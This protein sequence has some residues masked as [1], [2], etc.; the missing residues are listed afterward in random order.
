MAYWPLDVLTNDVNSGMNISPDLGPNGNH[1]SDNFTMTSGDVVAGIR[2]SAVSFDGAA[3]YLSQVYAVGEGRGLPVYDARYYTVSFWVKGIGATQQARAVFAE[4]NNANNNPFFRLTTDWASSGRTNVLAAAIRNDSTP[5][6]NW[7]FGNFTFA[8]QGKTLGTNMPFDGNWHHVVWVDSNGTARVYI[9]GL[10]DPKVYRNTRVPEPNGVP[11]AVT[12]NTLSLGALVNSTGPTAFFNGLID[13]VAVWE[14]ALTAEEINQ[15]RTN[16]ITLPILASAPAITNQPVGN[17]NLLVG[18]SFAMRAL[19]MGAHPRTY[20]WLKDGSPLEDLT[21]TNEFGEITGMPIAGSQSNL[22]VMTNMQASYSGSYSVI[23]SNAH[24]W[25][26]SD[27]VQILVSTVSPQPASLTNGQIAYWP[28]DAVQG[29]TTPEVVRG[30]DMVLGTGLSS[31]NIVPGKWG[32]AMRFNTNGILSRIHSAGDALPL[33]QYRNFTV[34]LWINAPTNQ[35]GQRFFA[36]GNS[37]SANPWLSLGQVDNLGQVNGSAP[38]GTSARIFVRND[39]N[40][41]LAAVPTGISSLPVF[42]DPSVNP[43]GV[44]HHLVYVQEEVGGALPQ[45]T[46][47]LYVDGMRDPLFVGSP[48]LPRTAHNTTIGGSLRSS[49]ISGVFGGG[50]ID[51][52]AVWNRAL[53][54]EE[55]MM[56]STNVTPAAL[57]VLTP[58]QITSFR[59]DFPAVV[60]GENAILRWNVSSTAA[61]VSIDQG[62]GSVL[63]RTTNGFGFVVVSNLTAST[64]FTLT[65][66]RGTN[67]VMAQTSIAVVNGVSPGWSLVDNFQTYSAGPLAN[68]FWSDMNGGSTVEDLGGNRMLNTPSGGGQLALLPMASLSLDQGQAR[69]LFARIYVQDAPN[70]GTFLN[71]LGLTDKSLRSP[72]D[73]DTDVGP[74]VRFNSDLATDLAIGARNGAIQPISATTLIPR[75]LEQQQVYNVWIDITN[76]TYVTSVDAT[77]T[78]DRF[79][80]WIQ[81]LGETGRTLIASDWVTDR[82]LEPDFLTA[83]GIHLNQLVVGNDGGS[84][85]TVYV[86]D[87]YISKSGY[88]S[89]VPAAWA[90]PTPPALATPS[91]ATDLT[92]SPGQ[93]LFSWDAGALMFAPELPGPWMVVPD[94]FGF[95]F[96]HTIESTNAQQYFRIQR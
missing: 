80:I 67:T 75:K 50:M 69:T 7:F 47:R 11:G 93:M 34:S 38:A 71:Q 87:I 3:K 6:N 19:A 46:A 95:S 10:A 17:S 20:Q 14:R 15:V 8:D 32:N 72:N 35:P 85:A 31:A 25:T 59:P 55:I 2:G 48:R 57:P 56:L 36:E 78:G 21:E 63:A 96:A 76:G 27:P 37:G 68:A 23:I 73:V 90:G 84:A 39:S 24:G 22:L 58:L 79:S 1:L 5:G 30:Y 29:I 91:F 53:T 13:D 33:A 28:L 12:L 45:L 42:Y 4:A 54:D 81:R 94:S 62:I 74:I 9:D 89:T 40:Q 66:Q 82:D 83:T 41:N 65:I 61:A 64:T 52:V 60:S 26:Q 88:N 43:G 51:D 92:S 18:D 77:N 86:D 49:G 44:W 70:A 16:G